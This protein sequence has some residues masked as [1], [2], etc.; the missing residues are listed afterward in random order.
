LSPDA[1]EREGRITMRAFVALGRENALAFLNAP[2]AELG[3]R[4]LAI[5]T[6]SVEGERRVDHAIDR[7][8]KRRARAAKAAD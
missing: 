3:G 7:L 4:P 1:Q 5:A 2:D 6:A 8:A